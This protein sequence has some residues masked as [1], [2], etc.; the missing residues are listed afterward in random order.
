MLTNLDGDTEAAFQAALARLKAQ[1][2]TVI[3]IEMPELA[4]L[5]GQVGFPVA[6]YEAYDDMVAYLRHTGTGVTIDAMVAQIASADV[7][8]TYEG[9]VLPRKLPA[10]DGS[11]V[12]AK[13][14]YD[15][16]IKIARPAL[17][18]LYQQTFA[19]QQ[20]RRHRFPDHAAGCDRLQSGVQQ[21]RE[22][23][24][25]H[26]E[27]RSRQQCR[28]S[29]NSDSDCARRYQQTCR[30][31]LNST[32]RQAAMSGCLRS[33][34]RSTLCLGGCRRRVDAIVGWAKRSVP[35]ILPVAER[36]WA[37]R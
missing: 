35:T 29:R 32:A 4:Q 11:F 15:E 19:E 31:G 17:Q 34:W 26:P 24:P 3:E 5:N 25:V 9:L 36:W 37:R 10:P 8:G 16:A 14:L 22:F 13:P 20:A 23:R 18:A 12:D 2:V 28:H 33:A 30:L 6:L 27:H 21:S 1:G 7:K